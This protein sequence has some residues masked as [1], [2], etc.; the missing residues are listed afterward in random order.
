MRDEHSSTSAWRHACWQSAAQLAQAYLPEP[1][2]ERKRDRSEAGHV[3][4]GSGAGTSSSSGQQ[5]AR[6][7]EA[8]QAAS[9]RTRLRFVARCARG[10]ALHR[11]CPL[12]EPRGAEE[13][14]MGAAAAGAAALQLEEEEAAAAAGD[15]RQLTRGTIMVVDGLCVRPPPCSS[16]PR[17]SVQQSQL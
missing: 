13:A 5:H 16:R 3:S 12:P 1:A 8:V 6:G 7:A 2:P 11:H 10:V 14:A 4:L 17:R 9:T 15:V